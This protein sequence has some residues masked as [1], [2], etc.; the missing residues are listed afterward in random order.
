MGWR[1]LYRA[2]IRIGRDHI[3]SVVNTLVLAY[4]GAALPLLL[5]FSIAQSSVG[6]VANSELVAEEIVRTLVGSIG[7]VAS[8]PVTT[9]LAALVVSAD[10]PAVPAAATEPVESR[11]PARG[12]KGRRRKR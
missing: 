1:D 9:L 7:L 11:A 3:A 10:R 8:V 4:A 6:T 2:G 12:G 5:L